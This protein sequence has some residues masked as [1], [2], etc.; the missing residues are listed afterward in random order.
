MR[1]VM[2]PHRHRK[3]LIPKERS[4][5]AEKTTFPGHPHLAHTASALHPGCVQNIGT[6]WVLDS[7]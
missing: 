4:H 5:Q 6:A 2:F 1:N 7:P 3:S